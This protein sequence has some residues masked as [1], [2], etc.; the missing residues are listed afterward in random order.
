MAQVTKSAMVYIPVQACIQSLGRLSLRKVSWTHEDNLPF[1]VANTL[2]DEWDRSRGFGVNAAS[3]LG[4]R[5]DSSA[6][7]QSFQVFNTCYKGCNKNETMKCAAVFTLRSDAPIY[8]NGHAVLETCL[9]FTV[10]RDDLFLC[11]FR[12]VQNEHSQICVAFCLDG[13]DIVC[14]PE[15]K[16][17]IFTALV[18]YNVSPSTE[19]VEVFLRLPHFFCVQQ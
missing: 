15:D 2:K 6:G 12:G 3:R 4:I 18:R 7:V 11:E 5:L 8:Q 10:F 14:G 9:A 16:Y 17:H 13:K 19:L 1:M